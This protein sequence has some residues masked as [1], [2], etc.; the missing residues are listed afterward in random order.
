MA[1]APAGLFPS[2]ATISRPPV[3]LTA[4]VCTLY[5]LI[6]LRRAL[7]P[8]VLW[9]LPPLAP[10][11]AYN[12]IVNGSPFVFGYQD[13]T[14]FGIPTWEAIQG[15]LFSAGRGLFVFSPFLLLAPLGLWYGWIREKRALY[16]YLALSFVAYLLIMAAWG[17]LGGWA[18]G[19]RMLTDVLPAMCLLVIPA[20]ERIRGVGLVVLWGVTLDAAIIQSFGLWDYGV[21]FHSDPAN[22]VWSLENNE[23][24][25]YLRLYIGMIQNTLGL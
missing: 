18:Y 14:V 13:G 16:P 5:V 25:F 7:I 21:A 1:A 19:A 24:L 2:L 4:L 23:P 11:L 6:H 9:A 17:S 10:A 3:L 15:L 20:V 8:F 12:A 22:S